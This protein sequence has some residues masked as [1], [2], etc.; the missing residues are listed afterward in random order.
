M[1]VVLLVATRLSFL[2][3]EFTDE[4][5]ILP[6]SF[7]WFHGFIQSTGQKNP[8]RVKTKPHKSQ[9]IRDSRMKE[10][11]FRELVPGDLTLLETG[12]EMPADARILFTRDCR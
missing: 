10:I 12:D 4:A 9:V 11:D 7:K 8:G 1:I 6:L 5:T 2:M 3:G